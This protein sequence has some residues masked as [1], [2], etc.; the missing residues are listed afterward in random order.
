MITQ[1]TLFILG[2]GASFPYGYP[3][4]KELR[5]IL[6]KEFPQDYS[7]LLSLRTSLGPNYP[8]DEDADELEVAQHFADTFCKSSTPSIDL[9]LA[10][11]HIF[12]EIG[13]KAIA[14]TIWKAE[15]NSKFREDV[16]QGQD[17]YTYL[18][19]RMTGKILNP[20][21]YNLIKQ[22]EISFVTF[23]YDRS[24]E[25][26]LFESIKNSFTSIPSTLPPRD[27]L[28]PFSIQH[29]YGQLAYLPWQGQGHNTLK[30]A[31][32]LNN[33]DFNNIYNNVRVIYD[34][35]DGDLTRIKEQI[36][37]A[38]RIFFLGFGFAKENLEVLGIPEL[39]TSAQE[40]Y[41]TAFGLTEKEIA[42]VR[43]TLSQNFKTKSSQLKNP[44]IKNM[45]CYELLREYL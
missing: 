21:D 22:N 20:E 41:G 3:T 13:R 23:N 32:E 38:K 7:W 5:R 9:F 29:V 27:A 31:A 35:T 36:S 28:F 6:C 19:Q 26:F 18:Y 34:R 42:S 4:G 16:D 37:K 10:R 30:Y 44:R 14:L 40:I 43:M 17:W 2:A 45:N 15:I 39:L 12:S 25:F 8:F 24:L 33:R 1:D 11:N